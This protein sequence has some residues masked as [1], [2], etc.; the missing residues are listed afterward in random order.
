MK[1]CIDGLEI[2]AAPGESLLEL[3]KRLGLVT[4]KLSATPLAA[5]IAGEVFTLNYIPV[6]EK[7]IA[8]ER[9]SMR[10]AMAASGGKVSLLRYSDTSGRDAYARTA[11]FVMF[12]AME[13]LWP[14]AKAKMNCTLGAGL[15]IE[16][17]NAPDF[18]VEVLKQRMQKIVDADIPLLRKR[19]TTADAIA[20]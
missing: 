2:T 4:A 18:S 6:R 12:L 19:M 17:E 5:R 13:Q 14:Q 16:V 1:L 15:L 20:Y 3:S 10:R 11:R 7:D 9:P 8:Q